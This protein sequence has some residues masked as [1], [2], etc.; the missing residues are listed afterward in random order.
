VTDGPGTRDVAFRDPSNQ[1]TGPCRSAA[2]RQFGPNET[3]VGDMRYAD[4]GKDW[5]E[6]LRHVVAVLESR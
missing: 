2:V 3:I 1:S 6:A 4:F 5:D